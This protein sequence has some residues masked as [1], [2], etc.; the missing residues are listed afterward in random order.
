MALSFFKWLF[1]P[2]IAV[3]LT[4]AKP[5][6]VHP[7]HVSV[8][9]IN[10]NAVEK[11]LEISCKIFTDDFER[12]LAKNYNTKTDLI[13]PINK[14]AMDTLVKKYL[15]SHLSIKVNGKA[16][17]YSYLGFE[18]ENEAVY[19]YIEVPDITGVSKM[20][21]VNNLMYDQFD[22]QVNI[23]HIIVGGKRKSNKLTY[24]EKNI[25]FTF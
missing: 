3:I 22:D 12:I 10:H 1:I 18:N 5:V 15:L 25:L 21:I 4:S 14:N 2:L 17:T 6:S 19:G 11:S 20:E 23:M 9:E 16:V 24:P 8:T 13:N 7:F